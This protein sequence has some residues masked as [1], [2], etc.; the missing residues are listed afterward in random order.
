[1]AVSDNVFILGIGYLLV[2]LILYR[3]NKML[4]SIGFFSLSMLMM[5]ESNN[6]TISG[7]GLVMVIVSAISLVYELIPRNR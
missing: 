1:M 7:T 2:Y 6:N 3:K 4:G 5:A